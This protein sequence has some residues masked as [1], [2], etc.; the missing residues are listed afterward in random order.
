[1]Q[2]STLRRR[3]VTD[4]S[5]R[6]EKLGFLSCVPQSIQSRAEGC[7]ARVSLLDLMDRMEDSF[8]VLCPTDR[9][10]KLREKTP[11]DYSI[12]SRFQQSGAQEEL[13]IS[14]CNS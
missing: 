8:E 7:V 2:L 9:E 4:L 14:F 11:P 10:A 1:M 3:M 6:M 13:G 12:I 5:S